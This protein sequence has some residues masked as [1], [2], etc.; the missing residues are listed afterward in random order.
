MI[1]RGLYKLIVVSWT[2]WFGLGIG[3]VHARDPLEAT[4]AETQSEVTLE[5]EE[6]SPLFRRMG[7]SCFFGAGAGA[8]STL[9][10]SL[11]MAGQGLTVSTTFGVAIGAAGLGCL[12][13]F[14]GASAASVFVSWWEQDEEWS[15]PW[16]ISRSAA[17]VYDAAEEGRSVVTP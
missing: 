7:E 2:L 1:L 16:D 6:T 5:V 15:F 14:A 4:A 11:P 17:S 8:A 10:S 3:Q 13:G 9:L 12:V